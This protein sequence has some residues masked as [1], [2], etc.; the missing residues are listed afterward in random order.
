MA[1]PEYIP[2]D[3]RPKCPGCGA[4]WT[5][6]PHSRNGWHYADCG[7][8]WHPE[9]GW[10]PLAGWGCLDRQLE[11]AKKALERNAEEEARTIH[12]AQTRVRIYGTDQWR[13]FWYAGRV[14][15]RKGQRVYQFLRKDGRWSWKVAYQTY[16]ADAGGVLRVL[17]KLIGRVRIVINPRMI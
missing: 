17:S 12:V 3:Q 8:R 16:F 10:E 4:G 2:M 7:Q 1:N 5:R 11:Q 15:M 9:R 14:K 13:W 6:R